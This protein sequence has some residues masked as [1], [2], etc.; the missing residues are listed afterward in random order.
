MTTPESA[1]RAF[2]SFP[3]VD[4]PARHRDYNEW[5]QLDHLPQNLAL[6]GVVHGDRWV[7]SPDCV[8]AESS[9]DALLGSAHY[10]AMYWFAE[11]ATA[12]IAEWT[13]LGDTT[14]QQGRRPELRWT[15]RTA[16]GMF[17]P[18]RGYVRADR[19]ITPA[20]LPFRP[21]RGVHLT[22]STVADPTGAAAQD[23]FQFYDMVRIP[24]LLT[25]P[26]V[27]GVWTFRSVAVR[28]PDGPLLDEKSV[29][30]VTLCYLESD[31]VSFAAE[32][33]AA[34]RD[35]AVALPGADF[36]GVEKLRLRSPLRSIVPW[37]WN[38]FD[39]AEDLQP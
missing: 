31:P 6:P 5:H 4:V 36:E 26:G 17:C 39:T 20:A 30:R 14:Q 37:E 7:R 2:F 21:H 34:E 25:L 18:V 8:A 3:R 23:L 27:A 1:T 24:Q 11:P 10:V 16:L 29:L 28:G 32:L 13:A 33:R 15:T 9:P 12:S 38:W 19:R 35:R 22:V